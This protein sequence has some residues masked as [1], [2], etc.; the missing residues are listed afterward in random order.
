MK[1]SVCTR[2]IF[3]GI[4]EW[5]IGVG[6]I[7][8]FWLVV[9]A[10]ANSVNITDGLDGLAGGLLASSFGAYAVNRRHRGQICLSGLLFDSRRC[11]TELHLVQYLSGALLHG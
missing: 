7:A 6:I 5:T 11:A 4:G 3:P 1:N 10:T 9:V 8:L 2:Y